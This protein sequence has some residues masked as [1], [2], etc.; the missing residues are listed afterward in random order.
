MADAVAIVSI[1]SSATVAIAVPVI[2]SSLERKRLRWQ[3]K[4]ARIDEVRAV[5][6]DGLQAMSVARGG[7][8]SALDGLELIFGGSEQLED[9]EIRRVLQERDQGGLTLVPM[10]QECNRLAV[11]LGLRHPVCR[12]ARVPFCRGEVA[13]NGSADRAI[14]RVKSARMRPYR[15]RPMRRSGCAS[16]SS[17]QGSRA[18]DLCGSRAPDPSIGTCPD[19]ALTPP[20]VPRRGRPSTRSLGP[21]RRGRPDGRVPPPRQT[22]RL[23]PAAHA[24]RS[25]ASS[26]SRRAQC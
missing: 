4:V 13:G 24:P 23:P 25:S 20:Q 6:D 3:G 26:P 5:M 11:R 10:R 2:S 12:T 1:V 18:R 7:L 9:N 15:E 8:V 19:A 22:R 14:W 21:P 16:P 17:Q